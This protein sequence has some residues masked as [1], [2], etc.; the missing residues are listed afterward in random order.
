MCFSSF[1]SKSGSNANKANNSGNGKKLVK[2]K[3]SSPVYEILK[4]SS[5]A[6]NEKCFCLI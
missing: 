6:S 1:S 3:Y 4:L 2:R 5:C